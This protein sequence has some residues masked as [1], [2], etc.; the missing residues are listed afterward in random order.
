MVEAA[1]ECTESEASPVSGEARSGVRS[2]PHGRGAEPYHIS[3][4]LDEG[5][6]STV[7]EAEQVQTGRAVAVKV[8][9]P[10]FASTLGERFRQ[11]GEFLSRVRHPN[12]VTLLDRWVPESGEQCLVFERLRGETLQERLRRGPLSLADCVTVTTQLAAALQAAHSESIVHRDVKPSNVFLTK[13]IDG[14]VFAKLIDFGVGKDLQAD[15]DSA[16]RNVLIGSP[17]YMAPEQ[18]QG[19]NDRVDERSDQFALALLA[20]VML[21]GDHPF[22]ADSLAETLRRVRTLE[23]APASFLALGVPMAVDAVIA[24]AMAKTK[25]DRFASVLEFARELAEA[26]R[27]GVSRAGP[28]I[29]WASCL[30][31]PRPESTTGDTLPAGTLGDAALPF[32]PPPLLLKALPIDA[33]IAAGIAS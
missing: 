10:G 30:A 21:T 20:Y 14:G 17:S 5:G 27:S 9:S 8:L 28:G 22:A 6:M 7:Y 3:S 13:A 25:A 1:R 23:P 26:A 11:E 33:G 19:H 2:L 29:R 31:L 12:V 32:A 18:A 24:R 4:L 16:D 15:L